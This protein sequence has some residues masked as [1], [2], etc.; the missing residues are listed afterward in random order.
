MQPDNWHCRRTCRCVG[1]RSQRS[2]LGTILYYSL[3]SPIDGVGTD[4]I[5]LPMLSER[6]AQGDYQEI[7]LAINPTIEGEI[8]SNFILDIAK[9]HDV[10]VSK[11]AHGVPVGGDLEYVD[12]TTLGLSLSGRTRL[13]EKPEV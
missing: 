6:L 7:I 3:L 13:T 8:T 1:H 4:D 12:G 9:R 5:G 10:L 11:I 2:L